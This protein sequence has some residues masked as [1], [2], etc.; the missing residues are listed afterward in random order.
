M[1]TKD[2]I[3][4]ET[5][6]EIEIHFNK[7]LQEMPPGLIAVMEADPNIRS[8]MWG[9]FLAGYR[10]GMSITLMRIEKTLKKII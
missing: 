7:F 5:P 6:E 2:Q 9:A 4:A 1:S 3:V 10:R 8:F